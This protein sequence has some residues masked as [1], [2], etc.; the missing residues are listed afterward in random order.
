MFKY[1]VFKKGAWRETLDTSFVKASL[2]IN[3]EF[4]R[5]ILFML[6]LGAIS[7]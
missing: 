7:K 6:H 5:R 4:S 1:I 3:L 2:G